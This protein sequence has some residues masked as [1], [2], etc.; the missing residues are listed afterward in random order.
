MKIVSCVVTV[1]FFTK[2]FGKMRVVPEERYENCD[3][4]P[5]EGFFRSTNLTNLFNEFTLTED[6]RIIVN[7]NASWKVPITLE[8]K[9]FVRISGDQWY[10]GRWQ[11]RF[12]HT[13]LDGC[14]DLFNP[15]GITYPYLKDFKRCPYDE[16]VS[17]LNFD[18]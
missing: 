4:S 6:N 11:K 10:L 15:V 3:E 8:E 14:K 2:T 7:S 5:S 16:N 17:C 9:L 13:M 18:L 12:T 1:L